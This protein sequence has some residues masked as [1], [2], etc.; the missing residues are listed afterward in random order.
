MSASATQAG[1]NYCA[2]TI[3]RL[4]SPALVVPRYQHNVADTEALSAGGDITFSLNN[5]VTVN[6]KY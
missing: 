3:G 4:T 6:I 5:S 1:H 2:M